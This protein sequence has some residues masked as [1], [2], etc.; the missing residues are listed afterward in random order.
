MPGDWVYGAIAVLALLH[1]LVLLSA[2]RNGAA[3]RADDPE[4][5]YTGDGVECPDC[6][7][8]NE[9]DYRFCRRCVSELPGSPASLGTSSAPQGRRT[10]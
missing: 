2:Y 7:E 8:R 6:G 4:Q 1:G 10:L 3:A 5:Y 9:R